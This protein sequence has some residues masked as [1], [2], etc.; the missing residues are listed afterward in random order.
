MIERK[1]SIMSLSEGKKIIPIYYRNGKI[2]HTD[3]K[4]PD[5][6]IQNNSNEAIIIKE[7]ILSGYI[8]G[9][10]V[11]SYKHDEEKIKTII[12]KTNKLLNKLLNSSNQWA[13]YS[14]HTLFGNISHEQ[15]Y[16][17]ETNSLITTTATCIRL[18]DLFYFHYAGKEKIEQINC[19]VNM[20]SSK[21]N[22]SLLYPIPFTPYKC[23]GDYVFPIK[24]SSTIMGTPWNQVLGHRIASSQEFAFDVVDY[25][26]DGNGEFSASSPP[27][28]SQVDDYFLFEREVLAI[29]DGVVVFMGNQWPNK[30]VENPLDY[31][32]E[33]IVELTQKLL[34]D[35]VDFN[36]AILGNYVII[37]HL[38]GEFSLYAHMSENSVLVNV[39]D[40]VKQ[41]QVI[42]RVGNTSNSD[43]P[44]LHFH[45]MDSSDFQTANGLPIIFKNFPY[46]QA[47]IY[48]FE[49]ANSLLYSDYL[50]IYISE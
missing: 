31:S 23:K 39:G 20:Y 33:R 1:V 3:I 30:W 40:R 22:F 27:N 19:Q 35:G 26:R 17:E 43:F 48:D 18:Q 28:S 7:I 14:L 34:D 49:Y 37:D 9:K 36:H 46:S 13:K 4:M 8:Q 15:K 47:P 32:E 50:F 12:A 42:G 45:L 24:G 10:E 21:G 29:G 11:I 16:Y 44:H 38:N 25:R 5:I 6:A 41:G 2:W